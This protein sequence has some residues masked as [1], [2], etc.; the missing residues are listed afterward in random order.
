[1]KTYHKKILI[2]K[3]GIINEIKKPTSCN[4]RKAN[5]VKLFSE[6]SKEIQEQLYLINS[7]ENDIISSCYESISSEEETKTS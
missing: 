6:E 4:K 7:K 1:M 5:I 3:I 2:Q